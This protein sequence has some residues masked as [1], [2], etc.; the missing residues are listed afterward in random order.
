ML[1]LLPVC[2]DNKKSQIN[3]MLYI[4][5]TAFTKNNTKTILYNLFYN[6]FFTLVS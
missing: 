6:K 5:E 3:N 4:Y 2:K 1:S